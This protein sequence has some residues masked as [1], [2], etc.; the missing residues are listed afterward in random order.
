MVPERKRPPW[1]DPG[2]T[3]P[4]RFATVC[5]VVAGLFGGGFL[6]TRSNPNAGL[7]LV[8]AATFAGLSAV[9]V[10]VGGIQRW[11]GAAVSRSGRSERD[12]VVVGA[13]VVAVATP[14]SVEIAMANA[15]QVFGWQNPVALLVALAT[16]ASLPARL[17]RYRGP[18]LVLAGAGLVAWIVWL[19]EQLLTPA[20]SSLNFSFLPSDLVG[21]GWYIAVLAWVIALD[22]VA[23]QS[24]DDEAPLRA[25]DLF[26]LALVPGMALIRLGYKARG[27]LW[28]VVAAFVLFLIYAGAVNPFEFQDFA[29]RHGLP[30]SRPRAP[31]LAVYGLLA[32]VWFLSLADTWRKN[33]LDRPHS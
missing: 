31:G 8:V 12:L 4:R 13:L 20:F 14:W 19:S 24:A 26:G 27:R 21:E 11:G 32:V 17:Q 30:P 10:V 18:A 28:L 9:A 1:L 33:R 3:P 7:F 22:G 16:L 2:A 6:L 23:A 15:P 29:S 5:L 25:R